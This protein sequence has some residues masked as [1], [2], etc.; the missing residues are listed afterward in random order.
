MSIQFKVKTDKEST[1]QQ[2][3]G[4]PSISWAAQGK[5]VVTAESLEAA[6]Y[7]A[8]KGWTK[9][10]LFLGG[11][12]QM[13]YTAKEATL[14][15]VAWRGGWDVPGEGVYPLRYKFTNGFPSKTKSRIQAV[16][17]I[18]DAGYSVEQLFVLGFVGK[19]K[20]VPWTNNGYYKDFPLGV[21]EHLKHL[22]EVSGA[23][24]TLGTWQLPFTAGPRLEVGSGSMTSHVKVYQI[25]DSFDPNDWEKWFVGDEAH[26]F[27]AEWLDR[28]ETWL[29]EWNTPPSGDT[30]P[31]NTHDDDDDVSP[32]WD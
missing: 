25:N 23:P 7:P 24:S 16:V 18:S 4:L 30:V 6:E 3:L 31:S 11:D 21:T 9:E 20:S 8:P 27:Y 5:F 10:E 17:A 28:N 2:G 32:P 26:A 1:G 19:A 14:H 22:K 29:R 12:D 15:I 13:C